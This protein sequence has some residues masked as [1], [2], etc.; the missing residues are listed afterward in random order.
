MILDG[1]IICCCVNIEIKIMYGV[2]YF[3]LKNKG[4]RSYDGLF[5]FVVICIVFLWWR[6]GFVL[7]ILR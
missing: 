4:Y 3:E 2:I 6:W 5:I 1:V 7:V